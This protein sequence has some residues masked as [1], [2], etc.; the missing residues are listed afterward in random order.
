MLRKISLLVVFSGL[1]I[2]ACNNKSATGNF[3]V[4]VNY[5]NALHPAYVGQATA[6][7]SKARR[8][9]MSEIPFG[10]DNSPIVMDSA[11]L[12][13][14]NGKFQLHGKGKEE[15]LYQLV[16]DNGFVVLLSNDGE[17]IQVNIDL[18]KK[19]DYYSVTGSEATQQMKDFSSTYTERS[20]KVDRAFAEMDSLKHFK[21]D[22]SLIMAATG[23]KNNQ[24]KQLNDYLKDFLNKT[25][26]P[27]V[28]LFVL[29][30]ASRSFAK[31]EFETALNEVVNKF[32][33]NVSVANLKKTYDTQQAQMA[34]MQKRQKEYEARESLWVGKQAPDLALPDA[35]GLIKK[36][37]SFRGKYL[38]VDFWASWCRPCRMENPNVV[39]AYNEFK[40]KNFTILGVSLDKDKSE[41]LQ[42]INEDGLAWTHVSDLKFW[43]SKA[44]DVYK[45][46]GIPYNI[47]I[48]PTGKVIAESLRGE[49]LENKLKEVLNS[50]TP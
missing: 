32:P 15:G 34:E 2:S 22:D 33:T 25:N 18:A 46:D 39:T 35:N 16:F 21:A 8:V 49:E 47:L 30:W 43:S 13:G 1:F 31:T 12:T 44:V 48:D 45:F 29:G 5:K 42:A 9:E 40:G 36:I 7:G 28:A 11:N 10:L 41:W 38:L 6:P 4:E 50:P 27:S 26:H 17:N 24:I 20:S 3:T 23:E 19:D 37:S 14:D